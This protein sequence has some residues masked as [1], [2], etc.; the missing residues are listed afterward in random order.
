M[1][2]QENRWKIYRFSLAVFAMLV[3]ASIPLIELFAAMHSIIAFSILAV[4]IGFFFGVAVNLVEGYYFLKLETSPLK[5]YGAA[6]YGLVASI[7][8]FLVMHLVL[9]VKSY[10]ESASLILSGGIILALLIIATSKAFSTK[11]TQ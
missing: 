10:S 3:F 2:W 5:S 9:G 6:V 1:Q 4:C 7:S 8:I 11:N